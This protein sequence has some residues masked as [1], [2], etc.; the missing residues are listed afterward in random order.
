MNNQEKRIFLVDRIRGLKDNRIY[1]SNILNSNTLSLE[2]Y[3]LTFISYIDLNLSLVA[4]EKEL[5]ILTNYDQ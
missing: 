1:L 2:E 3:D 5:D 4:L